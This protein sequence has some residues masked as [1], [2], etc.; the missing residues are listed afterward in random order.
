M[1]LNISVVSVAVFAFFCRG[2]DVTSVF[3]CSSFIY[4]S[5][6]VHHDLKMDEM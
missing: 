4:Y 3:K 6:K 2:N 5:K 1:S